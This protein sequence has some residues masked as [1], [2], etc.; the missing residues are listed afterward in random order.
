[1]LQAMKFP[2]RL[3]ALPLLML[4]PLAG[5]ALVFSVGASA[6]PPEHANGG[7]GGGGGDD[8]KSLDGTVYFRLYTDSWRVCSMNPDGGA[9]TALPENVGINPSHDLHGGHRWF[10]DFRED[11]SRTRPDGSRW[12]E[13][14]AVRGDGN[15]DFTVQLTHQ[16]ELEP[17]FHSSED[18]WL[19]GDV[20]IAFQGMQWDLDTGEPIQAGVYAAEILFDDEGNVVG[21]AQ[22]P[23]PADPLATVPIAAED[24]DEDGDVDDYRPMLTGFDFS[25]DTTAVAWA[26]GDQLYVTDLLADP[27]ADTWL[28]AT[29]NFLEGPA[30]SPD[31]IEIAFGSEDGIETVLPDGSEPLLVRGEKKNTSLQWPEWSPDGTHMICRQISRRPNGVS[32]PADDTVRFRVGGGKLEN[33]TDDIE[34]QAIP[35]AWR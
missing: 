33:L 15:E 28:I 24:W 23:D 22:Q 12:F 7:G 27:A 30:W 5:G 34:G 6:A 25:P 26:S 3:L 17:T 9:K 2:A 20:G 21:L 14:F 32:A 29:R 18:R 19:V 35:L 10:I 31:G 1:M 8:N 16:D 13:L 4:V 11:P